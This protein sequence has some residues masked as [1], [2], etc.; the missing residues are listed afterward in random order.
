MKHVKALY[1]IKPYTVS[2]AFQS[3]NLANPSQGKWFKD[4]ENCKDVQKDG[5]IHNAMKLAKSGWSAV[6]SKYLQPS[7]IDVEDQNDKDI[8]WP[9]T[10]P[11]PGSFLAS[12]NLL[13]DYPQHAIFALVEQQVVSLYR[14]KMIE[15][16]PAIGELHNGIMDILSRYLPDNDFF[17]FPDGIQTPENYEEKEDE[18]PNIDTII[19]SDYWTT[20]CLEY[21]TEISDI[22][23][24]CSKK[25]IMLAK[26][27]GAMDNERVRE[28][29][30]AFIEV[31]IVIEL[32][33]N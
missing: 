7:I 26:P 10:M 13:R 22:I 6:K 28:H 17:V 24:Y 29:F 9:L 4:F 2:P 25:K 11:W 30:E 1:R 16:S 12:S 32:L 8:P 3:R 14:Q 19:L 27:G 5:P 21:A 15:E 31:S 23:K 33:L 18:E 20:N